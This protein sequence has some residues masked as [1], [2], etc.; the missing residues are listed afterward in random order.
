[1][2]S[3]FLL[4]TVAAFALLLTAVVYCGRLVGLS[5]G[6]ELDLGGHSTTSLS[7][8]THRFFADELDRN[9][10][11]T[12]LV[13]SR[14]DMP[15][16]FKGVEKQVRGLLEVLR[17]LA[18]DRV[19][20]RVVDPQV[21]GDAGASYAAR[22]K[23]SPISVR[24]VLRDEHDEKKIWS[25]L[26]LAYEGHPD[27]LIQGIETAHLP[28]LEQLIL[29]HLRSLTRPVQPSFAVASPAGYEVFPQIL[30][31]HGP[32]VYVDMDV[33]RP[34]LPLDTDIFFWLEPRRVTDAHLRQ[35]RRYVDSGRSVVLAGSAY[36]VEYR[37]AGDA[38]ADTSTAG[39]RYRVHR[40]PPA[41]EQLLRPLGLRPLP[42]LLMDRNAGAVPVTVDGGRLVEVEAPF[43][44]RNL[45][46][47]RD[48]RNFRTPARG[49]LSFVAA[50]A[51]EI[52][53]QRVR[54]AGFRADVV[55][56]TTEHAWVQALPDGSFDNDDLSADLT[57]PKQNLMV[58][59]TS[60]DLWSGQILV[61]A[62]A[63]PFRDGI[64]TR[65]GYGHA[66][67]IKDLVRTFADP[68]R[69]VRIRVERPR[70]EPLP[71][72]TDASRLFWR[73]VAVFLIPLLLLAVPV[74]R[75]W[76]IGQGGSRWSALLAQRGRAAL[77][78]LAA[79]LLLVV[80]L[81]AGLAGALRGIGPDLTADRYNTPDPETLLLLERS[82]GALTGDLV[83][84]PRAAM[85]TS[86]KGVEKRVISLF[87]R[88]GIP[89][90]VVRPASLNQA[91]LKALHSAGAG[92][93]EVK[94]VQRDTL[95]AFQV[96]SALQL[97]KGDRISVVPRLD[98]STLEHLDFLIAAA[99][100]RLDDG[101]APMVSVVSDLPRLS[102]AE[103]LEDYQKKSLSA[104]GGVDV[105][106][107]LKELLVDYGY[108]LH[109]VNP[110]YPSLAEDTDAVLWLQPRRD[111]GPVIEL[112][113][114]FLSGG[115]Q[116]VVAMQHFNIQQR[117]YR[118][119]GFR[120]VYWPQPQFQDLDRYLR[121]VGVEQVREVLMDRTRHRLK[122]DTQVNRTAVREYDPQEVALPFLIRAVGAHYA[123]D[124]PVTRNLGDL[125][126]IWGN[127]FALDSSRLTEGGFRTDV[128]I[129]T[130]DLSWA[131]PWKGGWLPPEV[132]S[133]S[134]NYL[135]GRQPL[136]V[137]ITGPFP[138]AG[139]AEDD[140]G[141]KQLVALPRSGDSEG[142]LLLLGSS[143]MFKNHRLHSRGF[144][145]AQLL[146]NAVA[147][148]AH[149]PDMARLQARHRPPRGFVFLDSA[150]KTW[151]RLFAVGAG[152]LA[153]ALTTVAYRR[154]RRRRGRSRGSVA[155]STEK[156]NHP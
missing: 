114:A 112:V 46:A 28:H 135:S 156:G 57:V 105:Y 29:Q 2:K 121:L 65:S 49:G 127:R 146:L 75:F 61:A 3:R 79:G 90:H 99:V 155:S 145:H 147:L 93:F 23:V 152:P 59:L 1:M 71:P 137:S 80:S 103:A 117:Q 43:H 141:R 6:G 72:M 130:S 126:F 74:R 143:E 44:L 96:W 89:L 115:G 37:S 12:Y 16:H 139:F 77:R 102:P 54:A 64:I 48:F 116:T 36:S 106:S 92:P 123:P 83:I 100:R 91:A 154:Y 82:R 20:Y 17:R 45:P 67:V 66:V 24:R 131:Y 101:E 10:A 9:L 124:S 70:P 133:P 128:I 50:S 76:R 13:S 148:A 14:D 51:L 119:T 7:A 69:L 63:S 132:L 88:V 78:P 138:A 56:T 15:S 53:P 104:P 26:V 40:S 60:E 58:L 25:S 120:T 55:A 42:D 81:G 27:I 62:S 11:I 125:L 111:S 21:S 38:A 97:K 68:Q 47:F 5:G 113:S 94:R 35:L 149:G 18:P 122:L 39:I 140:E 85:P 41:W 144:Q 52:D 118:G 150:S 30:S 84:S 32:V 108:R 34:H 151:W 22:R 4:Q 31:Q 107:H 136:A 142:S 19:D 109:H 98:A 153:L 8:E 87:D 134:Q 86:L 95:V 110:R 73:G 33:S 129:T